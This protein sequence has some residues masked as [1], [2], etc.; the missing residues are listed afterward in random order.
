LIA[1]VVI[2]IF[3]HFTDG[4]FSC[5][6]QRDQASKRAVENEWNELMKI[7][8]LMDGFMDMVVYYLEWTFELILP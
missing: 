1:P 4:S 5:G 3:L 6:Q 8:F 7:I 2:Y